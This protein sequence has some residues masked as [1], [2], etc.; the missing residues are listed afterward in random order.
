MAL[1]MINLILDK[2]QISFMLL[3]MLLV[4]AVATAM[5]IN[6][7]PIFQCQQWRMINT[8]S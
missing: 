8:G 3:I 6:T 7:V 5:M 4:I 2:E 1:V